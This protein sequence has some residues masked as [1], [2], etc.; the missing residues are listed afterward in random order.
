MTAR[1]SSTECRLAT[2]KVTEDE[3]STELWS[4]VV[5]V[6]RER[7][8]DTTSG[9][10]ASMLPNKI[11]MNKTNI[12]DIARCIRFDVLWR[13]VYFVLLPPGLS[14]RVLIHVPRDN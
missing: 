3:A 8:Y 10:K 2:W 4:V 12:F 6:R 14:L 9:V 1:L 11:G 7:L 5:V 13:S